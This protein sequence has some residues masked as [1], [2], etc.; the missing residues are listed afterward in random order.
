MKKMYK[1]E[2]SNAKWMVCTALGIFS[3]SA[4]AVCCAERVA[5]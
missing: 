3:F 5:A 4:A 2:I 1:T